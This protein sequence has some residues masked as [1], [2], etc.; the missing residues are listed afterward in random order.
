V[1]FGAEAVRPSTI[2]GRLLPAVTPLNKKPPAASVV[3]VCPSSET[4]AP[5][6]GSSS[7]DS[8]RPLKVVCPPAMTFKLSEAVRTSSAPLTRPE[9]RTV[10]G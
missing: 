10:N 4:V 9:P 7:V 2:S 8:T 6:T 1:R 5:M 3:A